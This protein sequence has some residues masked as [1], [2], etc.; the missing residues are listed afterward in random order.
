MEG[1]LTRGRVLLKVTMFSLPMGLRGASR[2]T[3]TLALFRLPREFFSR[4]T[5]RAASSS[6]VCGF[7][8]SV[9]TDLFWW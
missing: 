1:V 9:L 4:G 8:S 6:R 5:G 3:S 7:S 2:S